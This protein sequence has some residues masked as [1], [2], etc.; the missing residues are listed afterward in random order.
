MPTSKKDT[1]DKNAKDSGNEPVAKLHL[2]VDLDSR[3]VGL[4]EMKAGQ[5]G[6]TWISLEL[7]DPDSVPN[8]LD[9]NHHN[10]LEDGG[11]YADPM[12]FWPVDAYSANPFKSVPGAVEHP[13]R[14]HQGEEKATMTFSITEKQ[15][16]A[17][18]AY[19]GSKANA[20]YNVYTYNCSTF[21]K[22][23][24][25]AAGQSPPSMQKGPFCMPDSVYNGILKKKRGDKEGE[26]SYDILGESKGKNEDYV[27]QGSVGIEVEHRRLDPRFGVLRDR[28][29]GLAV[30]KVE[31][32]SPAADAPIFENETVITI[33]GRSVSNPKALDKALFGKIGQPVQFGTLN[34]E[35]YFETL[36]EEWTLEEIKDL[37]DRG[38][39]AF[40]RDLEMSSTLKPVAAG[41]KSKGGNTKSDGGKKKSDDGNKKKKKKKLA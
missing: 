27:N 40:A 20:N 14:H 23:A 18:L 37:D 9:P 4:K 16:K 33:G 11:K 1:T 30:K 5:V 39:K 7:N 10:L 8:G 24:I 22:E 26:H 12:G 29:A 28:P 2:M 34:E 21:A 19:A 3:N 38:K 36:L 17:V 35:L 32:G 25:K 13:D 6:H 41:D 31:P 15:L